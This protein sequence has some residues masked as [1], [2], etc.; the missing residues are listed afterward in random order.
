MRNA[1]YPFDVVANP[2]FLSE[3]STLQSFRHP[4]QVIFGVTNARAAKIMRLL[5][6]CYEWPLEPLMVTKP[7][8][9]EMIKLAANAFMDMKIAFINEIASLCEIMGADI[10]QVARGIGMDDRSGLHSLK[11]G[12]W[13]SRFPRET[14]A[15][16]R[17]A[18]EAG[19]PLKLVEAA[20]AVHGKQSN[21][22]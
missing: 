12:Y 21:F 2:D 18:K 3:G 15:L 17:Q 10:K 8:T 19:R 13:Q 22:V 14:R 1:A 6:R 16:A 11:P 9:A 7:E 5:Y 4:R 20:I